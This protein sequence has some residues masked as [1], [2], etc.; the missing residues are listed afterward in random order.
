MNARDVFSQ[1]IDFC[2]GSK[3]IYLY[4]N[5]NIG[6]LMLSFLEDNARSVS[7]FLVTVKNEQTT[8]HIPVYEA[9]EYKDRL[10]D[11]C[12]IFSLS[13]KYQAQIDKN[14]F[15]SIKCLWMKDY[16]LNEL[17]RYEY[18][19]ATGEDRKISAFRLACETGYDKMLIRMNSIRY[20]KYT[21]R[22][23]IDP[24]HMIPKGRKPYVKDV[25]CAVSGLLN[26]MGGTIA[27]CGC[28]LCDILGD[29]Q[30]RVYQRYGFDLSEDII[31]A[32]KELFSDI[33][34]QS[35]SFETVQNLDITVFI[36]VNFIHELS[37]DYLKSAYKQ[38]FK[39]NNIKYYVVDEVTGLYQ[40]RHNFAELLPDGNRLVKTLGPYLS[41]GGTRYI[42]I[43]DLTNQGR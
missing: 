26:G 40:Y 33:E 11:G 29:R 38:L 41:A 19:K 32:D 12:V 42:K 1:I 23:K 17:S 20:R 14:N 34:F 5:G 18:I 15:E 27:E 37:E 24:W 36:S 4:G 7:G 6:K 28:G 25:I 9:D 30:L 31:S 10:H 13:E 3:K 8:N 35:G 16:Q 39:N 2:N 22:F 21:R 43:F